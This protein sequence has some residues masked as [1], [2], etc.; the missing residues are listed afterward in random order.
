VFGGYTSWVPLGTVYLNDVWIADLAAGG[1]WTTITPVGGPPAPRSGASLVYD[2]TGDRVV[3]FGGEDAS[4]HYDDAWVLT[5]SGTPTWTPVT[6]SGAAPTGRAFHGAVYDP[7]RDR[8]L[9]F[10]GTGDEGS[11]VYRDVWA[12][13]LT[14]TPDWTKLSPTGSLPALARWGAGVVLDAANDRMLVAGGRTPTGVDSSDVWSLALAGA[15]AWSRF[16]I[17]PGPSARQ[18]AGAT[19]DPVRHRLLLLGGQTLSGEMGDFWALSFNGSPA[20][21]ELHPIGAPD[22]S[23]RM[24]AVY[25]ATGDAMV[26]YGGT[27]SFNGLW[28]YRAA[29][30][31]AVPAP[32]HLPPSSLAFTA[33]AP[34]PSRAAVDLTFAVPRAEHVT[35]RI[36]DVNGRAV[37]TLLD[38]PAEP[39][40]HTLRWNA[41][42]QAAGIYF[43]DLRNPTGHVTR[44]LVHVR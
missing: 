41:D 39:G 8:M 33:I 28:S 19:F 18:L 37:A 12:L 31:L 23:A 10:G 30:V 15:G 11:L 13:S 14:G 36:F 22:T 40:V 25:D 24:G 17:P 44:R 1:T 38:G 5:L 21:T 2:P 20:W 3:L 7:T 32:F 4:T 26:V 43:A 6:P 16:S 34:N 35:L 9:T 42:R 27:G 29:D